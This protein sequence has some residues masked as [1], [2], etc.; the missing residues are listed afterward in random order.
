MLTKV[1]R[2]LAGYW[3]STVGTLLSVLRMIKF[4]DNDQVYGS[5]KHQFTV[6]YKALYW[7]VHIL[8]S[9]ISSYKI[10]IA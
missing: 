1:L 4:N 8:S 2:G 7:F 10:V 3:K 9:V 5:H 6:H